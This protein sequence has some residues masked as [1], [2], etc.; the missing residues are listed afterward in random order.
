[1]NNTTQKKVNKGKF[2]FIDFLVILVILAVIGLAIYVFSPWTTV[3]KL[4]TS[5]AV[6]ITYYVEVKDVAP[7]Y[8]DLIKEGDTVLDAVSKNSIGTISEITYQ[9]SYLYEYNVDD[10]GKVSCTRVNAPAQKDGNV[11]ENITLK[12]TVQ[13][14]YEKGVGYTVNGCRVAIGELLNIR[15]PKYTC[16]GYCVQM[17]E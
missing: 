7:E 2:N 8:I 10:N 14:D 13:A 6:D 3:E 4:W 5:D 9:S 11:A 17:Y 12:I 1:M 16:S 15:L